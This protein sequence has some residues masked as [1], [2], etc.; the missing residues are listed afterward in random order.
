MVIQYFYRLYFCIYNRLYTF[1][2]YNLKIIKYWLDSLWKWK[3]VTQL[4]LPP[5]HHGP[6][7]DH[8]G[9]GWTKSRGSERA[10]VHGHQNAL[11]PPSQVH[12]ASSQ[13]TDLVAKR[14]APQHCSAGVGGLTAPSPKAWGSDREPWGNWLWR[15]TGYCQALSHCSHPSTV[16]LPGTQDGKEQDIGLESSSVNQSNDFSEPR[17]LHLSIHKKIL[18]SLAWA[19]LVFFN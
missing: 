5:P 14:T 11:W 15:Q 8:A 10:R 19:I 3:L 9:L 17:L 4:C 1:I 7:L 6:L 13:D 18:N 12:Q 2:Y 16:Y